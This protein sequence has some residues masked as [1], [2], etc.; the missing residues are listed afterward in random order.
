V[1]STLPASTLKK[2]HN[3]IAYHRVRE[4]IATNMMR[5]ALVETGKNLA[6]MLTKPLNGPALH[7]IAEKVLYLSKNDDDDVQS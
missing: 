7:A 4:A 2:K 6:D 5:V 3:A 1:S